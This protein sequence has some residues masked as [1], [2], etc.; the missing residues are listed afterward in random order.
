LIRQ[1]NAVKSF[2]L[3]AILALS[4]C[5]DGAKLGDVVG[6]V[7][8]DG[9]LAETGAISFFPVDGQGPT[10]GAAI[11]AG[12]YVSQAPLGNCKVEIRVPKIVGTK[13]LYDTPESPV[14]NILEEVL[15]AKYNETSE[16]RLDVQ[17]GKNAKNWDLS[18]KS[19]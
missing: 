7:S 6:T 13:K 12:K 3:A 10:T 19:E 4:G 14:Q 1:P 2:C 15:P 17:P 11:V 5:S 9:V 16:L 18:T 8:V